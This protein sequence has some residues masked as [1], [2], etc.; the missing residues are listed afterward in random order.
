MAEICNS[1]KCL[2]VASWFGFWPCST[3]FKHYK[4]LLIA[5]PLFLPVQLSGG[6][7]RELVKEGLVV[8]LSDDIRKVRRLFLFHDVLVSS[9]QKA[10]R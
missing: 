10:T 1:M 7:N 2:T 5:V 3:K 8:E 4:C 9:K 6:Y